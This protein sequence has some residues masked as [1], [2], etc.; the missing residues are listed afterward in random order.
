MMTVQ[1]A[2]V[3]S[4]NMCAISIGSSSSC[5]AGPPATPVLLIQLEVDGEVED[6]VDGL[7]VERTGFE[8]PLLDRGSSG[9][10]EAERQ[11]LEDLDVADHT[12]LVDDALDDHDARDARL[13]RHFGI[14]RLDTADDRRGLDVA[15]DAERSG[16]FR[17]RRHGVGHDAADHTADNATEDT[18]LDATFHT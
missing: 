6:D 1:P 3:I 2:A 12:V 9:L 13:A 4:R 11:R 17:R 8:S 5:A 14:R 15:T 7:A 16:F 10:I 18:A